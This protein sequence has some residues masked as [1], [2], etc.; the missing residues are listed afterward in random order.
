M[1]K[2]VHELVTENIE[3]FEGN[4]DISQDKNQ[5]RMI[6]G[7]QPEW[8]IVHVEYAGNAKKERRQL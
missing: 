4:I 3:I 6:T 2:P 7:C 5:W 1:F 8:N